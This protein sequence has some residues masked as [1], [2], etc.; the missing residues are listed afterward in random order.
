MLA[1]YPA[2]WRARYAREVG[3]LLSEHPASLWT[4]LDLVLSAIDAHL[5]PD[6]LPEGV[7]SMTSR[8]RS[9]AIAVWCA[10]AVFALGYLILGRETDPRPPFNAVA[11]THADVALAWQIQS[12]SATLAVLALLVGGLPILA[13]ALV[14]A[15]RGGRRGILALVAW[16]LAGIVCCALLLAWAEAVAPLIPPGAH[17]RPDTGL[18]AA[19]GVTL[20]LVA[21][22]TFI[23]GTISVAIAVSRS[24]LGE[25]VLRF[26]VWPAA[27]ALLAMVV[28]VVAT[29][30][31]A[32]FLW[33]DD[34]RIY[35][36]VFGNCAD[37]L[38][39][40]P[41]GD[42]GVGTVMLVGG[43]MVLGVIICGAAVRRA[44]GARVA[45]P[46]GAAG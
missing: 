24:A 4:V 30:A 45:G 23:G 17:V 32:L 11:Q 38:C 18:F 15:W 44:L 43:L 41:S 14:G 35:G 31:W 5:H 26:A 1:L 6:Y 3:S 20:V 27:V 8:L 34:P 2:A 13:A 22:I 39:Y 16:P 37:T 40:G 36:G 33:V 7:L 42:I 21:A 29:L 19:I 25:R 12:A 46:A 9:S 28:T 10:F